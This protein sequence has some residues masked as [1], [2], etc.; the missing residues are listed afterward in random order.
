MAIINLIVGFLLGYYVVSHYI[1]TGG[2]AV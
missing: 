1:V 2:R